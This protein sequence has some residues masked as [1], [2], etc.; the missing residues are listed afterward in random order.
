M[1][2]YTHLLT[3]HLPAAAAI[4]QAP[5][6][7]GHNTGKCVGIGGDTFINPV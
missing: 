3:R 7:T 4:H 2:Y 5:I 1:M 6:S